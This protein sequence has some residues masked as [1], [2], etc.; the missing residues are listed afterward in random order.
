MPQLL[1]NDS[2]LSLSGNIFSYNRVGSYRAFQHFR[3]HQSSKYLLHLPPGQWMLLQKL[4]ESFYPQ[5]TLIDCFAA[6]A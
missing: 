5:T 2:N 1:I 3:N 6:L 4:I